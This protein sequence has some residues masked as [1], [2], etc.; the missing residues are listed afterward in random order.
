MFAPWK[1]SYDKPV[2]LVTQLFLTLRNPMDCSLPGSSGHGDCPVRN[3]GAGCHALFQGIFPTQVSNSVCP[4]GR[5]ILYH[6]SHQGSLDSQDKPRQYIQKQR[7]YFANK[8]PSSQ[9]CDF[10]SN[11]VW[12]WE[13]DNK[14]G[15]TLKDW[16]FWIEVLEKIF[17]FP[18]ECKEI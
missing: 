18:L 15:W 17:E 13:M 7:H 11:H 8:G 2:H 9:L 6:M 4:H 5:W 1:K 3:T 12:K 16:C 14:E 10:Y